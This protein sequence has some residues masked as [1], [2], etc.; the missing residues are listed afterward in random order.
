MTLLTDFNCDSCGKSFTQASSLRRHIKNIH[1][2]HNDFKFS[3]KSCGKSVT[4]AANLVANPFYWTNSVNSV[5]KH[6]PKL[7]IITCESCGKSYS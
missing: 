7:F 5:E 4:Q 1:K 2:S 3:W 6:S